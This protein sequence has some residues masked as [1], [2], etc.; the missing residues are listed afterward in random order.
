MSKEV[1]LAVPQSIEAAYLV[2]LGQVALLLSRVVF[3]VLSFLSI[4][5][6]LSLDLE[7][8]AIIVIAVLFPLILLIN[9]TSCW[10]TTRSTFDEFSEYPNSLFAWDVVMIVLFFTTTNLVSLAFLSGTN[11]QDFWAYLLNGGADQ[12][13]TQIAELYAQVV[14]VVPLAV[15]FLCGLICLTYRAWNTRYVKEKSRI[16]ND[17]NSDANF[18]KFN[19]IL[20]AAFFFQMFFA[21]ASIWLNDPGFLLAGVGV[22]SLFWGWLNITWLLDSPLSPKNDP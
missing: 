20:T 18:D 16:L 9:V 4:G 8:V 12:N 22:W 14:G 19:T 1:T 17:Q 3:E 13:N 6:T 15:F 21:I 2:I 5:N 7:A 11:S 10:L